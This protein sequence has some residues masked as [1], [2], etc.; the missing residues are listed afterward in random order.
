MNEAV[1]SLASR[2]RIRRFAVLA[3]QLRRAFWRFYSGRDL[4]LRCGRTHPVVQPQSRRFVG[5]RARIGDDTELFCGSYKW[6][7]T[8][9]NHA[10]RHPDGLRPQGRRGGPRGGGHDR[11]AGRLAYCGR[12]HI[13]PV[14]D[15]AGN[16][17]GAIGCILTSATASA[18]RATWHEPGPPCDSR[19][20]DLTGAESALRR[21]LRARDGRHSGS[22]CAG[23]PPRVNEAAC[24]ITGRSRTEL[25]GGSVFDV[26][27]SEDRDDDF[28]QY[29]RLVA[30]ET[31][32][33]SI[34]KR[35]VRQDGSVIWVAVTCSSVRDAAGKFDY[36]LAGT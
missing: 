34:E 22:R 1:L 25:I 27:H 15:A 19:P 32:R 20:A 29:Q 23:P 13:E 26:L 11:A 7:S 2:Q 17:I 28:E 30:G 31:D 9:A 3:Q 35:I 10:R 5:P 4:R 24:A 33:Y 8:A 6:L 16:V 36:G 21:D 12:V 18:R 14:K